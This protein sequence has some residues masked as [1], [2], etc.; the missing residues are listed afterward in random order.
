MYFPFGST[1]LV[2]FNAN[3]CVFLRTPCSYVE[4]SAQAQALA[5]AYVSLSNVFAFH[6]LIPYFLFL[7]FPPSLFFTPAALFLRIQQESNTHAPILLFAITCR[8]CC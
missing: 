2:F 3:L 1:Y 4:A 5:F 7:I 6:F 8:Q